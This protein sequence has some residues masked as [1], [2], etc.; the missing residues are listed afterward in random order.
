MLRIRRAIWVSALAGGLVFSAPA[1]QGAPAIQNLLSGDWLQ[2][3]GDDPAWY[4]DGASLDGKPLNM[5]ISWERQGFQESP[6]AC[7]QKE[8]RLP[9]SLRGKPL[10]CEVRQIAEH[11]DVYFNGQCLGATSGLGATPGPDQAGSFPL[12]EALIRWDAPN[13][14]ALRVRG[15][16]WTGGDA[17]DYVRL[18]LRDGGLPTAS[19]AMDFSSADHV[20]ASA[21]P[22]AIPIRIALS[23]MDRLEGRLRLRVETAMHQQVLLKDM[24]I[25]LP[26]AK[27]FVLELGSLKPGFYQ[28]LAQFSSDLCESQDVQWLAVSPDRIESPIVPLPGFDAFWDRAR[29][30][31]AKVAPDSQATL[32]PSRSTDRR[33]VHSVEMTSLDGLRIRA[34]Y[35]VPN[36]K[37][38]FPAV[39]HVPGYSVAMQP[40]WFTGDDGLI[41][42]GLDIRGHGR[43]AD[44]IH[45]GFGM[46]G[47][48]GFRIH[49]ADQYIY[50]GAYMDCGRALE[51]LASRPEV[52]RAR[53]AVEGM[54]QGGGL[55]LAAAGL[56][57][58]YVACCASAV[59]F[60]GSPEEHFRIRTIYEEEMREHLAIA[61][62]GT[63]EDSLRSMRMVD[64]RRFAG[65]IRC[66][67]LMCVGLFDDD[68]PPYIGFTIYNHLKTRKEY[69]VFPNESHLLG[70]H[71]SERSTNWIRRQFGIE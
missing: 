53:I 64:P 7:L 28:V 35:T 60:L 17:P 41:H 49:D 30:D 13:Q 39:L 23:G 15:H 52:D 51:F 42:L 57:P 44:V 21:L 5:G 43:S 66:P 20:H 16:Q 11:T 61:K 46:P 9:R 56:F 37:G 70:G 71:W 8:V 36:G 68:C 22:V 26:M 34:W 40:D 48:V 50:R 38:P 59:P 24:P 65:R 27:P 12:P 45:P 31:L 10:V 1:A 67:V 55:A 25:A 19:I 29:R 63:W 6:V 69:R 54:S 14:L 62:I 33:R 3:V 58:E 32:D 18:R 4:L 47:Y 2:R